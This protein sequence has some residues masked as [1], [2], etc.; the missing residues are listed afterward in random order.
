MPD[1]LVLRG[2]DGQRRVDLEAR[3]AVAAQR[4]QGVV[5]VVGI[6]SVVRPPAHGLAG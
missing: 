5:A 4:Q 1:L 3:H 6:P 2:V